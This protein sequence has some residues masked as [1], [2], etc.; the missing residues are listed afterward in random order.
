MQKNNKS[1]SLIGQLK[2]I[3]PESKAYLVLYDKGLY[4]EDL[5]F[6]EFCS[7]MIPKISEETIDGYRN[8]EEY[9]KGIRFIMKIEHQQHLIDLYNTYY[10]KAINGDVQCA[11]F[12]MEFSQKF[13][14]EDDVNL[15]EQLVNGIDLN[16]DDKIEKK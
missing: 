7:K 4:G 5:S 11:K 2:E 15:L 12:F 8:S 9:A 3:I 14:A 13:F 10:E 1:K 6:S 16:E